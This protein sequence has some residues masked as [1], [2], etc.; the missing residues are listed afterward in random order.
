MK[1]VTAEEMRN[2]DQQT[3][4]NIGIPG[5]VLMENAG[6]G[7]VNAI[8]K[9]YA[10]SLSRVSIF[11]GKGNNGGDGLVVARHLVNMGYNVQ[12]YV[13]AEANAF[14]G[15]ALINLQIAK[16]MNL[17]LEF[18]LSDEDLEKNK[19]KIASS[20]LLVDS[21]FGTGL[22]GAVRGF[23]ANVIDFLNSTGLPIV[24]IDL[25]SGLDANTGKIDGACIKAVLTVTMALPK[26][27]L[28]MFPGANYV[29]ELKVVD[30][31]VPRKV[32]ESQG[33]LVNLVQSYD[34]AKLLPE[35]PRDAHKGTFGRVVILAGSVGF[36]GA[37]AMASEA[38]LRVGAGLVS[39]GIPKSLNSIMGVKLTEAMTRPL[40]ET[41]NLTLA[42]S[43]KD[44]IMK[45]LENANVAALG[46]GLSRH[47]ETVSLIQNLCKE[48]KI[49]KIIDAD[50]LNA[51]SDA[52]GILKELGQNT[53]LTPHPGEMAR[54]TANSTSQIQS[55]RI[56]IAQDFAKENGVVL[57]LKGAPTVTADSQGNVFINTTGNPG[58]A[59]GGTG[60]VLTGAIA[61]F[62]AQGLSVIDAAVLGVY[63]HGLAGD[64]AAMKHGEAGILAR[65]VIKR[66]PKAIQELKHI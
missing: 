13:M 5:I 26:R 27:G 54:L 61:G 4:Q 17:P 38:A 23:A 2:I 19:G 48:V 58:L 12:T 41:E 52:P 64:L 62:L 39:L 7:V 33:I 42:M 45:M 21:I 3:I 11:V 31:G 15:D 51:L 1:I 24:A 6:L 10:K 44:E 59:S 56:G 16:N 47:P 57:V 34:A 53:I 49:P 36:T 9:K 22:K 14:T 37:A 20:D 40:P 66:L 30:I 25:P 35:R 63:I 60:D 29:G 18:I 50:G 8:D 65:D 28:L 55:D 43:A 46:P 32:I